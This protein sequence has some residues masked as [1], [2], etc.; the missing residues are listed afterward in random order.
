MVR[1][2]FRE[3]DHD[4]FFEAHGDLT[5]MKD[6]FDFTSPPG[7]LGRAADALFLTDY[8]RR[9]IIARNAVIKKIA[10]GEDW[11]LYLRAGDL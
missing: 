5:I 10:E 3:L 11:K 4:H 9:F 7:I 2:A 8:M 1:G 6:V